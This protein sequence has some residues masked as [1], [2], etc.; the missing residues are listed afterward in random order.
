MIC[1]CKDGKGKQKESCCFLFFFLMRKLLFFSCSRWNSSTCANI[2]YL[3]VETGKPAREK[4]SKREASEKRSKREARGKQERKGRE[5]KRRNEKMKRRR[6]DKR[7]VIL[8]LFQER[9]FETTAPLASATCSW[10]C[11]RLSHS[12]LALLWWWEERRVERNGMEGNKKG[13]EER[14][15]ERNG[16][17]SEGNGREWKGKKERGRKGRAGKKM[18]TLLLS[19]FL[20]SLGSCCCGSVYVCPRLPWLVRLSCRPWYEVSSV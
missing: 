3:L 19:P 10:R 11:L 15:R 9:L 7:I 17:G 2:Y 1:L 20:P 18:L 16:K 8:N 4:R 5:G 14:G 6:R 13:R 12:L